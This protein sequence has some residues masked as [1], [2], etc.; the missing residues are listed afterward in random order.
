MRR[1][2]SEGG[3]KR[4]KGKETDAGEGGPQVE[5]RGAMKAAN[6]DLC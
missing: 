5:R 4:R 3:T 6:M 1:T 2:K